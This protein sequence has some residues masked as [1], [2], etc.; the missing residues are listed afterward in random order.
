LLCCLFLIVLS[1]FS[2]SSITLKYPL[3]LHDALPISQG[4]ALEEEVVSMPLRMYFDP[5]AQYVIT[6]NWGPTEGQPDAYEGPG[7][8]GE[9]I[10]ERYIYNTEDR[11]S[12]V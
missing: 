4:V 2:I 10:A 5:N 9:V 12:V 11:K 6:D 3:S 7:A 8:G 1:F